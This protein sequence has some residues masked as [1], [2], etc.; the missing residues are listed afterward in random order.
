VR[1]GY[2]EKLNRFVNWKLYLF[3]Y[4]SITSGCSG[5]GQCCYLT[6]LG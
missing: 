3:W 6:T 2:C 1:T 4:T 5:C